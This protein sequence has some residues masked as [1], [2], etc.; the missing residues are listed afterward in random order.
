MADPLQ[1]FRAMQFSSAI[2]R[3]SGLWDYQEL[4]QNPGTLL[5]NICVE[6]AQLLAMA[7]QPSAQFMKLQNGKTDYVANRL[8]LLGQA[9]MIDTKLVSWLE[10]VPESWCPVPVLTRDVPRSVIDTGF[11]GNSCDVYPD[12]IICSTWNEWRVARLMV[13][14]LIVRIGDPSSEHKAIKAI[15]HVVDGICDSVPFSLGDRTEP[16]YMYE[17]QVKYPSLPGRPMSFA[18]QKTAIAYGGWYLFAPFKQTMKVG[19]YLRKGQHD[20][21]REQLA[22]LAKMYDVTPS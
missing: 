3:K 18:H 8:D 22:R 7:D 2:D 1:I 17:A 20:W 14:E 15:Q 9:Q 6:L 13:L 4:P 11:Y 16:G 5:D 10:I 19:S 21:L 12:I